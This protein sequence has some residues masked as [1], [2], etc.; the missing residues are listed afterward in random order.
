MTKKNDHH[1]VVRD[2][3]NGPVCRRDTPVAL[4]ALSFF[5]LPIAVVKLQNVGSV[6]EI[7]LFSLAI[8]L[9]ML[10]TLLGVAFDSDRIAQ[11]CTRFRQT[12]ISQVALLA[13]GAILLH[14]YSTLFKH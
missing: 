2:V 9:W 8:I 6:D 4:A 12:C 11:H 3:G 5:A 7:T 10:S 1:S 14:L 13:G